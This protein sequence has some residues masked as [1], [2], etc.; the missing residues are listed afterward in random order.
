[1]EQDK[2]WR[3]TR[4][5]LQLT[6]LAFGIY[7]FNTIIESLDFLD[8]LHSKHPEYSPTYD[9]VNVAFYMVEALI[10]VALALCVWVL[11]YH[12][13]KSKNTIWLLAF[14]VLF[15]AGVVYFLYLYT[16]D[17]Y[18]WVPFIYKK[19]NFLSELRVLIIPMQFIFAILTLFW[20]GKWLNKEQKIK[21]Q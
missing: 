10:C 11:S 6:A 16:A 21:N 18:R 7:A 8:P 9:L 20:W 12:F 14:L 4:L 1:M 19:A 15:R 5:F 17:D 2:Y 13:K 3:R